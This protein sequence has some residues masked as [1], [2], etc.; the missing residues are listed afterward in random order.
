MIWTIETK[1]TTV[2]FDRSY[3]KYFIK[4]QVQT[5]KW[6]MHNLERTQV[7]KIIP[8]STGT[9][10]MLNLHR[11]WSSDFAPRRDSSSRSDLNALF[12][13]IFQIIFISVE[14]TYP[15]KLLRVEMMNEKSSVS[16]EN[17]KIYKVGVH[18]EYQ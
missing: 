6:S 2:G 9:S 10:N 5:N 3:L 18:V 17:E 7:K 12:F 13:F 16:R 14:F 4:G 15:E 8:I 1:I 11:D